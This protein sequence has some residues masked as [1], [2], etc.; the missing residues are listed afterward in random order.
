MRLAARDRIEEFVV[1]DRNQV[2]EPDAVRAARDEVAVIRKTVAAE[3]G[4]VSRVQA[5]ARQV[6]PELV[7]VCTL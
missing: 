6:Q 5:F 4:R 3:D 2:L 1:L 7:G